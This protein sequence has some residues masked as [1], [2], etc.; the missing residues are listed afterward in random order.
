MLRLAASVVTV[1]VL[2]MGTAGADMISGTFNCS[3]DQKVLLWQG[4]SPSSVL[5]ENSRCG[6]ESLSCGG[7]QLN[8]FEKLLDKKKCEYEEVGSEQVVFV[9]TDKDKNLI[10]HIDELCEQV[11][12]GA[13]VK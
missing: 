12:T 7:G 1:A 11:I 13:T 5:I 2:G 10:K 6:A 8:N 9:C 3:R 4:S